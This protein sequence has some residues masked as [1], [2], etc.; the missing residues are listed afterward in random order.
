MFTLPNR[1]F[2]LKN[3][4]NYTIMPVKDFSFEN[5]T[6]KT[7]T[8]KTISQLSLKKTLQTQQKIKLN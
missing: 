4:W 3:E 1:F 5:L 2:H 8:L 6:D 7:I